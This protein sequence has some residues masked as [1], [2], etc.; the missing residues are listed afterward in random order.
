MFCP[1]P[2]A[3]NPCAA[4]V[5]ERAVDW[6]GRQGLG[7][8]GRDRSAV[9]DSRGADWVSRLVPHGS[10]DRVLLM[11]KWVYW[12]FLFDDHRCDAEPYGSDLARFVELASRLIQ[13]LA[14]PA[15]AARTGGRAG[16]GD[17]YA[18]ALRTLLSDL[19]AHATPAQR[20]RWIDGN[21]C[22]LDGVVWQNSYSQRGTVA[23]VDDFLAFRRAT[24]GLPVVMAM[25]DLADGDELTDTLLQDPGVAA[26]TEMARLIIGIDND[27]QSYGKEMCLEEVDQNVLTVLAARRGNAAPD[28]ALPEAVLLRDQ[29][30]AAFLDLAARVTADAP[31]PALR[32][33]VDNLGHA[34]RGNL[35]WGLAVPRYL[36]APGWHDR[37]QRITT[38]PPTPLTPAGL[39]E[40]PSIAWWWGQ[41]AAL[42]APRQGTV[43]TACER[44]GRVMPV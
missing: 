28:E 38:A 5:H 9:L 11:A 27:L 41:L 14:R 30:M 32:R 35:D 16:R 1:I 22:W 8:T 29:I 31:H 44:S 43:P 42:P 20:R 39:A 12:G 7:R 13:D 36:K 21:R 15:R 33:Y 23:P 18:A 10:P 25:F 6:L 19:C 34:I 3:I 40:L 17:P 4:A 24:T 37:T 26:L 2:P